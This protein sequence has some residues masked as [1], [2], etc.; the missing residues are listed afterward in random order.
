MLRALRRVVLEAFA[1]RRCA[2][3]DSVSRD[4]LCPACV[5]ALDRAPI[6]PSRRM[7]HGT[8]CAAWRFDEPIRTAIHRGKFRGDRDALIMLATLATRRIR[9]ALG[10]SP[11]AVVPVPLGARRRRQRGY[12]QAEVVARVLAAATGSP[13]VSM[14]VRVR[15]TPAQSNR[16]EAARRN[17]VTGVFEWRGTPLDG[18]AVL[19]VD[20]VL[21]T[22]ATAAAACSAL[23]GA[24]ARRVDVA[25]LAAVP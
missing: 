2:A 19:L 9:P 25:V 7:P 18:A 21:T 15:N 10:V 22:G 1:P 17:N 13:M 8:A 5:I 12:N 11:A 23:A 6:P 14:L 3:C 4:A 24:G 16:D 20:D